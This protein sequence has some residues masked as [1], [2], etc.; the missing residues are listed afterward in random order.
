MKT[1]FN[2]AAFVLI[3]VTFLGFLN[4]IVQKKRSYVPVILFCLILVSPLIPTGLPFKKYVRLNEIFLI[5]TMLLYYAAIV[6]K[7]KEIGLRKIEILLLLIGCSLLFSILHGYLFLDVIPTP[8]DFNQV[9]NIFMF[10]FYLRFGLFFDHHDIDTRVMGKIFFPAILLYNFISISLLF[11]WGIENIMPYYLPEHMT[12]RFQE[13]YTSNL[14]LPRSMGIVGSANSSAILTAIIVLLIIA[15]MIYTPRTDKKHYLLS[16]LLYSS[17]LNLFLTFSRNALLSFVLGTAYLVITTKSTYK[18]NVSRIVLLSFIFIFLISIGLLY[19]VEF[20]GISY[21][22]LRGFNFTIVFGGGEDS[23]FSGRLY[24]W[25][26]GF[27]KSMLSPMFGWGPAMDNNILA[28]SMGL[29]DTIR[30]FYAPHSEYIDLLLTTGIIGFAIFLLFFITIYKKAGMVARSK[31]DY[32][33]MFLGRS[34]QAIIIAIAIFSLADGFWY[35]A[36]VPALLMLLFGAMY[37]VDKKRK[38][39]I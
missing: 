11:P 1:L 8:L 14:Y 39:L 17:L 27:W 26:M 29:D 36:I 28:V 9:F 33:S 18:K 23:A 16:I 5:A 37:A 12:T 31:I 21:E 34:V 2:V 25:Q 7:N 3:A 10:C 35:N 19:T 38:A 24:H 15:W 6:V 30:G 13:F 22:N 32:F 20:G 4:Y